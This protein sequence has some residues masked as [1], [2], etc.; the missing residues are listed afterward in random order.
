[1]V[2]SRTIVAI[3]AGLSIVACQSE[4]APRQTRDALMAEFEAA[5]ADAQATLGPGKPALW[6]LSDEDTTIH[7]FGTVHL[8]RPDLDW[9]S[10]AF[11]SAFAAADTVVFE[12]DMKSE[13][14][15]KAASMMMGARCE[16][17]SMMTPKLWLNLR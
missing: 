16:A 11:E 10:P 1:M 6:T 7:L 13:A 17:C 5:I 15:Q 4:E 3:V 8:L 9:R 2:L 12:V 14:G